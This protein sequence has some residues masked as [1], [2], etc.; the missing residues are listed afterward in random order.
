MKLLFILASDH[1]HSLTYTPPGTADSHLCPFLPVGSTFQQ[2]TL[3]TL[4]RLST[5][6]KNNYSEHF[7]SELLKPMTVPPSLLNC[8]GPQ[9]PW[10][11][12]AHNPE[13]PPPTL[14]PRHCFEYT[15]FQRNIMEACWLYYAS[16]LFSSKVNARHFWGQTQD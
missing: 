16:F 8:K 5:V 3:L 4:S 1:V 15:F 10:V 13:P 11:R 2:S 9:Q 6:L 7:F 12:W 14:P